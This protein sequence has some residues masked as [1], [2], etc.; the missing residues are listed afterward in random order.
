MPKFNVQVPH[1]LPQSEARSRLERFAESLQ[2][3][4]QN[5]VSELHQSWENDTLRFRFKT[6]GIPLDGGITVGEQELNVDGNLPFSAMM[7]RGKIESTIREELER[8]L[9]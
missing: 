9:A 2:R 8:L 5:Q 6:Y 7:F 1:S 4:F 3:K